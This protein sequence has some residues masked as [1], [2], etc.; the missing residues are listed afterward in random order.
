[1]LVVRTVAEGRSS[2]LE[3]HVSGGL[4][5]YGRRAVPESNPI[6][7][8][9]RPRSSNPRPGPHAM[10]KS[11]MVSCWFRPTSWFFKPCPHTASRRSWSTECL[12]AYS[13]Q[14]ESPGNQHCQEP[15]RNDP[16]L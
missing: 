12:G 9:A 6:A 11:A 15:E 14:I 3:P 16:P 10:A 8:R 7:R 2:D 4:W 5:I 13:G 1:M